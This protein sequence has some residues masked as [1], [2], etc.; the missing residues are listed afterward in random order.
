[1]APTFV[2]GQREITCDAL[3]HLCH[4]PILDGLFKKFIKLVV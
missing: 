1:M 3:D 2:A 4:L